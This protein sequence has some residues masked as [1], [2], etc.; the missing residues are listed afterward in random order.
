[1]TINK[2]LQIRLIQK[3]YQALGRKIH[4]LCNTAINRFG[5]C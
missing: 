1:M 5:L 2:P 4:R 3:Y